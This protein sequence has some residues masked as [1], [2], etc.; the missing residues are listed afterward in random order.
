MNMK[1][2]GMG[3]HK[4]PLFCWAIVVTAVLLLLSLPVLAGAITMLLTDRNFNTSFYD[5]AGGGDPV[6]YQ[7]LFSTKLNLNKSISELI[8]I[9]QFDFSKFKLKYNKYFI[10]KESKSKK[11]KKVF[12]E[13]SFPSI[14]FLSWL[15]G[16]TEGDGSFIV[17][18]RG[19]LSFVIT[20]STSDIKVL[21][22][23]KD[24]LKFGKVI[25]QS[26]N[27]SRFICQRKIE[28]ELIVHLFN[29]NLILP[30]RKISFEKFLA[31]FNIWV[32]KGSVNL[33]NV[34]LITSNILPSLENTWLT[35]FTDAEGCFSCSLLNNSNAFKIRFQIAQKG[36]IN[37]PILNH[38]GILFKEGKVNPHHVKN[39]YEFST[40]R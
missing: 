17:N 31:A 2:Y 4:M 24:N 13:N 15:I 34:K 9:N 10:T 38:L 26:K 22:Y 20:Q 40:L 35:G 27:N 25:Q 14:D 28:I 7:H 39:V 5:P 23:I 21:E 36:E 19:D 3:Y 16:F 11:D 32:K 30:S 12:N 37:L 33:N 1:A 18:N 29:G 6:L 8:I